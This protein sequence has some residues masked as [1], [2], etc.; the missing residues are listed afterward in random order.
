MTISPFSVRALVRRALA[1]PAERL[2]LKHVQPVGEF[3][4]SGGRRKH[5]GPE[6]G[7]DAERE[8]VDLQLVSDPRQLVDLVRRVKLHLV[9][10]EVV[11]AAATRQRVHDVVPEVQFGRDLD[12]V[13]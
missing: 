10:D 5:L 8:D 12:R 4:Q 1:A 6:V 7:E 9:V 11:D 2:D 13:P 3:D